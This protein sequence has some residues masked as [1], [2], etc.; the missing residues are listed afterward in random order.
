MTTL[1]TNQLPDGKIRTSEKIAYGMGDVA[2]NVVFA[3]TMSLSTYFYTNVVGMNAAL[4]GTILLLSR[5]FD[6]ISDVIMGVLVDRT[7]S[8]LGKARAWVLWMTVPYGVSAVLLFMVPANATTMIQAIYVFITYNLAITFVYTALNL[9]YGTLAALMTRDQNERAIINIYRMGMA[10]VGNMIVTAATLPLIN[11]LGGDQKAWITVTVVYA[12]IA[13][14][15][16]LACF[17]GCKERV[18]IPA[19]EKEEKVPL[20]VG[21]KAMLSNKYWWSVTVLFFCWA[22]YVTLNGTMLTYYCEYEL[23]NAEL[24]SVI[25]IVEKLPSIIATILIAPF[26]KKFGKRN[27]SLAGVIIGLVGIGV[28]LIAPQNMTCVMVGAA[29]KGVGVGPIGATVYSMMADAIEYGHWRTGIRN[30]G[31]LFSAATVGYKVGSGLTASFIGFVLDA[32]GYDGLA[33]VQTASAHKAISV[34]FLIVPIIAWGI[35]AI[36]LW[37]YKLDRDYDGIME[38]LQAGHYSPKAKYVDQTM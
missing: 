17:F 5:L 4:V 36:T 29:L 19:S 24:M 23:G 34:L 2:C 14:I 33:A 38:E 13:M 27:L 6:G 10:P 7:K 15:M 21:F 11:R 37:L 16:L 22:V 30:E 31:L 3:L 1:K 8:K 9:P 12:I 25:T 32:A 28:I 26:V 35:W 18:H 20:G